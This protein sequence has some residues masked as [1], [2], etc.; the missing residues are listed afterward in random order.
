[1]ESS[2]GIL[3]SRQEL[4]E[5]YGGHSW[6]GGFPSRCH[7]ELPRRQLAGKRVLDVGCRRGKGVYKLSELVGPSGFVVGLDWDADAVE[8]ARAGIPGALER[9]GLTV[10]NMAFCKGFPED[11]TS[12]GI[13]PCSV[14]VAYLNASL[15][16]FADPPRALA[17]CLRALVPGGVLVGEG[18]V[19]VPG[20]SRSS[21]RTAVVEAARALGNAVQ[22]APTRPAF[23]A[24]LAAAGF[25]DIVITEG[26]PVSPDAGR[27]AWESVPVV[28]GDD[29]TYRLVALEARKPR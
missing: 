29:A 21:A 24:L 13:G 3:Q 12:A 14:D 7:M 28:P 15:A 10:C 5:H 17:E 20:T 4:R 19:A 11:L 6:E 23:E 1:M 2:A 9:S 8:A 27:T 25:D 18:V 16:L 26:S 22:A